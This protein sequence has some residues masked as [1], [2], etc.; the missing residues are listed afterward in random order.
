MPT[1]MDDN[2]ASGRPRQRTTTTSTHDDHANGRPRQRTT[3]CPQQWETKV[4]RRCQRRGNQTMND[5][6]DVVVHT[7]VSP[8]TLLHP[9]PSR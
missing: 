2:H 9:I 1:S 3:T 7:K 8:L 6:N 4:P 5:N